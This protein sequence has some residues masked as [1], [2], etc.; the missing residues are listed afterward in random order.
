MKLWELFAEDDATIS[1]ILGQEA[2]E[3]ETPKQD[4]QEALE[5]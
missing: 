2:Q 5:K 4:E 3:P 1:Q